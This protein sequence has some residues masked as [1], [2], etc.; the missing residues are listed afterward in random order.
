MEETDVSVQIYSFLEVTA[1]RYDERPD[2]DGQR[3]ALETP[4]P[5]PPPLLPIFLTPS[6]FRSL[7]VSFLETPASQANWYAE[8]TVEVYLF[9]S[10]DQTQISIQTKK[11]C[12]LWSS[13]VHEYS[14]KSRLRKTSSKSTY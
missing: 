6:Q 1:V 13:K 5:P 4:P 9:R 11:I 12:K 3:C 8:R 14:M 2:I 7:R 10:I